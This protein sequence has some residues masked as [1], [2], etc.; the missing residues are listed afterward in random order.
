MRKALQASAISSGTVIL[1]TGVGSRNDFVDAF[2]LGEIEAQ[3]VFIGVGKSVRR[4]FA[5]EQQYPDGNQ[6]VCCFSRVSCDMPGMTLSHP[7]LVERSVFFIKFGAKHGQIRAHPSAH[8]HRI[9]GGPHST[10]ANP[11]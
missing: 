6:N 9:N 11:A 1:A 2:G 7:V 3:E 10:A 5:Y 8:K 4:L